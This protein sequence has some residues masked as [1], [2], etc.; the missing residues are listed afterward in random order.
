MSTWFGVLG[1]LEIRDGDAPVPI[2][3]PRQRSLV[4]VLLAEPNRVVSVDEVINRIWGDDPPAT[5]RPQV[6]AMVSAVR[7]ALPDGERV[8]RTQTSGYQLEVTAAT[9]DMLAF[10]EAVAAGQPREAL[11]LWRGEPFSGVDGES[12]ATPRRVLTE[13]YLA[14]VEQLADAELEGG[15]QR[16]VAAEL[17][18]LVE[19]YPL[20]EGLRRRLMIALYRDGRAG[21]ALETYRAGQRALAEEHGLDPS[22]ALHELAARIEVRDPSLAR[23]VPRQL[24]LTPAAFTGRAAE[25]AQLD[26][27]RHAGAR[28]IGLAGTG[29]VGK[30]AL[31]T[32]WAHRIA[33]EFG[34][35]QLYVDLR[36]YDPDAPRHPADAM[37]SLLRALGVPAPDVPSDD[38]D[39]AALYQSTVDGRNL[40][41]LL[42]NARDAEHV[43]PLLPGAASCLTV[44]TSRHSLD[45][46]DY[47][48]TLDTLAADDA[49][50]LLAALIGERVRGEPDA[51]A[52]LADRCARLP[53]ALRI[54]AERAAERADVPLADLVE[55]LAD[56]R[57][58]LHALDTGDDPHTA[59]A[60][61]FSWSYRQLDAEPARAFRLLGLHRGPHLDAA[62]AAALL[63]VDPATAADLL[64]RLRRVHLLETVGAQRFAMHDLLRVFAAELAATAE[65]EQVRTAARTRLDDHYQAGAAAA[66]DALYPAERGKRPTASGRLPSPSSARRWLDVEL[67]NLM[68]V[69]DTHVIGL[70]A[71]VW[72]HLET[73]GRYDEATVL[74]GRSAE[75]AVRRGDRAAHAFARTAGGQVCWRQGRFDAA[76]EHLQTAAALYRELRDHA[77]RAWVL[78][79]LGVVDERARRYGLAAAH[80]R[81][82]AALYTELGDDGGLADALGNL[83]VVHEQTGD[84]DQAVRL[85]KRAFALHLDGDN[86]AGQANA[87]GNV[88][89]VHHRTG[90]H[91]PAVS[92]L[93]QALALFE[94]ISDRAGEAEALAYLGASLHALGETAAAGEHLE[95]AMAIARDLDSAR[96]QANALNGLG[97]LAAAAG[98]PRHALA[99]HTAALR[100]AESVGDTEQRIRAE[101]G[102]GSA[103]LGIDDSPQ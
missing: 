96:V 59:V 32:H 63:D 8:L 31:A 29:G 102:I 30:T 23:A 81:E 12:L 103:E 3:R 70:C 76:R 21:E 53:L 67:P 43:R 78:L 34:D 6:H 64:D 44:V 57:T 74:C 36:G 93:R 35:G 54:A 33:A 49:L 55:E 65:K 83:G 39:R 99:A 52:R 100:L 2:T 61:V 48:V 91:E 94:S 16:M 72:R 4:A 50:A 66:M 51:A 24:P 11:R 45:V 41:L 15:A 90:R 68:T 88:G 19:R 27:L 77:G 25:L 7:R 79:N 86:P 89:I 95:R 9:L 60:A 40:L 37:A 22:P 26:E 85:Q 73:I 42:D 97:E 14:V 1:P 92:C 69:G 62:A 84:Y 75:V 20:R 17:R 28:V 38:G 47:V 13:R 56:E 18:A 87:L 82:A 10:D 46:F 98:D 5:A 80:L 58:V 101:A 71:T